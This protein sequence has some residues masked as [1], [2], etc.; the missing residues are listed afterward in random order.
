MEAPNDAYQ[1]EQA[2]LFAQTLDMI[3]GK[4]RDKERVDLLYQIDRA[5]NEH[6]A[7]TG[8]DPQYLIL[9]QRELMILRSTPQVVQLLVENSIIERYEMM[10]IIEAARRVSF[11]AVCDGMD[12][13]R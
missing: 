5:R 6:L 7:E 13:E 12:V 10:E 4:N 9:G 1:R 11:I 2:R 8:R 3:T